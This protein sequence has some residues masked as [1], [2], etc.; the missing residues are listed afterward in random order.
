M[1]DFLSFSRHAERLSVNL[2][3]QND[4]LSLFFTSLSL[5]F[6]TSPLPL[7]LGRGNCIGADGATCLSTSLAGLTSMQTLNIRC[8]CVWA[9][10][11]DSSDSERVQIL[12]VNARLG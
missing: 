4:S 1:Y 12:T 5:C 2:D 7:F 11:A 6:S 9:G 8:M 10:R 3:M